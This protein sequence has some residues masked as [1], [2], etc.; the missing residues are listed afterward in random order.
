MNRSIIL[1]IIIL[2]AVAAGCYNERKARSQFSKAVVAYPSIPADYCANTFPVRDSIVKDTLITV[3]TIIDRSILTDTLII[4]GDTVRIVITKTLSGKI[5]TKTI[6][7]KDTIFQEGGKTAAL[8]R[9]CQLDNRSLISSLE[10]RTSE[11]NKANRQA[12]TRGIILLG[13][14]L[15]LGVWIYFKIKKP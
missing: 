14:L 10:T 15:A 12:N 5:V 6:T 13:L 2:A 4:E 3:D 11:Y 8:L 7:I 9:S 1:S